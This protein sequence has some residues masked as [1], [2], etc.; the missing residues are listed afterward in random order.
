[1][2]RCINTAACTA[3]TFKEGHGG[4]GIHNGAVKIIPSS[5]SSGW[6]S[7][8]TCYEKPGKVFDNC[9]QLYLQKTFLGWLNDTV[10]F[11]FL[12]IRIQ[13]G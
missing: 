6:P 10:D 9:L 8:C 13:R 4:C 1:M 3:V 5:N 12:Y 7:G 2:E 11:T